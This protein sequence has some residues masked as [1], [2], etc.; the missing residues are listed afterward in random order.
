MKFVRSFA[1]NLQSKQDHKNS[2]FKRYCNTDLVHSYVEAVTCVSYVAFNSDN[3]KDKWII[4]IK[5]HDAVSI[6]NVRK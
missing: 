6:F 5:E 3:H 4:I 2:V 1:R